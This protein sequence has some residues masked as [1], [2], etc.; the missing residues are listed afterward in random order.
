MLR[1]AAAC[2]VLLTAFPSLGEPLLDR[3]AHGCFV[4]LLA[5]GGYGR[6]APERAAFLVVMPD[7][8]TSCVLWPATNGYREARWDGPVPAG[9]IAIAHTHPRNLDSPSAR[10][11]REASRTGLPVFVI[12]PRRVS[13]TSG[14]RIVTVAEGKWWRREGA[15]ETAVASL[16]YH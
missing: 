16:S 1:R 11:V 2:L 6:L 12:T 3:D 13:M 5:L 7:G 4:K 10:D 15:T 8:G 9:T 14:D